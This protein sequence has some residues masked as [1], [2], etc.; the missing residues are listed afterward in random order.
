[1]F[2][3]FVKE[4]LYILRYVKLDNNLLTDPYHQSKKFE[5]RDQLKEHCNYYE[6]L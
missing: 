2:L 4:K 5:Q 6:I 3:C 1:M